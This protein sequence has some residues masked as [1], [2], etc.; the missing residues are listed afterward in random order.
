MKQGGNSKGNALAIQ[1]PTPENTN[2]L[3]MA[4]KNKATREQLVVEVLK[5][6]CKVTGTRSLKAADRFIVQTSCALVSPTPTDDVDYVVRA[7]AMMAEM[8][9]R[10][11]TEAMLATQMI[12]V[13]DAALLFLGDATRLREY[14]AA[15]DGCVLRATR[16]LRIFPEL[17]EAMQRLKGKSCQQKVT[18][19][20]VHVHDGGQAIVGAVAAAGTGGREGGGNGENNGS[21]P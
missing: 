13:N 17:L 20:H 11:A 4:A 6:A 21:T 8:A 12:A 10:N 14:P 5:T 3:A 9:P 15:A 18:V 19:E 16:L 7:T 2:S 1:K